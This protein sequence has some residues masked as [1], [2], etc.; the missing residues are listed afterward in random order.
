MFNDMDTEEYRYAIWKA[1][2]AMINEHN[3]H[4]DT[5]GFTLGMNHLGD[6]TTE[7]IVKLLNGYIMRPPTNNTRKLF[8]SSP[9]FVPK[10]AVDWRTNGAVT[11]VKNQGQCGSCWAFSTTG[12]LEGQ[13]YLHNNELVSLSE[14][15][16]VDCSTVYGNEGCNGGFVDKAFQYIIDKGGIDTEASYPYVA[17]NEN[18][19][20]NSD[21][22]ATMKDFTDITV[23]STSDLIDAST[24]VG[25]I[26]VAMDASRQSFHFYKKGVYRDNA[27]STTNLDHAV[28]VVGYGTTDDGDYFLVKNSWGTDWGMDGYFMIS[29][30]GNMCGLATQA[31]Y[32]IV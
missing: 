31:S 8:K 11:P 15:N 6:M 24:N 19:R 26:S 27:C 18:C 13:H 10:E 12:S 17:Q 28:L 7:E 22:G 29:R 23:G 2:T 4:A 21:I 3:A 20:Y 1:N 32:P 30:E 9:D 5:H 25:P 16:L 14:Q